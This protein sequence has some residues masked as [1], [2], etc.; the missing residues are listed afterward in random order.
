[1]KNE[2]TITL[3]K[4]FM[5][6]NS[7]KK[8]EVEHILKLP[9]NSLSNFLSGKKELPN[10]W[11][12]PV[13]NFCKEMLCN[14]VLSSEAHLGNAK[15]DTVIFTAPE[16]MKRV[17]DYCS[18]A[19]IMPDDLIE[20]HKEVSKIKFTK[21]KAKDFDGKK[22]NR[23]KLDEVSNF[24]DKAKE[25]VTHKVITGKLEPGTNAYFLRNGHY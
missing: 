4:N 22:E 10:K 8:T 3:L 14:E 12:I 24:V 6:N 17:E 19:G 23:N 13:N 18:N 5:E 20:T 11:V 21:A 7:L 2:E 16:W 15:P 9:K 25:K 1:M